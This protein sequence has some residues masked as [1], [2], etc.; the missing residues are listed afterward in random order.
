MAVIDRIKAHFAGLKP[1]FIEVPEW[2]DENGPLV[3]YA[4]RRSLEITSAIGN[5]MDKGSGHGI[6]ETLIQLAVD[7]DGNKLFKPADRL[8]L[9]KCAEKDVAQRVANFLYTGKLPPKEGEEDGVA[10][11]RTDLAVAEGN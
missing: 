10:D 1:E 3:I 11:T 5:A 7:Q 6:V 2:G 9:M 4:R 8:E